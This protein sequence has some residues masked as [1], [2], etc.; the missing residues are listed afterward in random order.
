[1]KR[2]AATLSFDKHPKK[3]MTKDLSRTARGLNQ[4]FKIDL[5]PIRTTTVNDEYETNEQR[6]TSRKNP[7]PLIEDEME[8]QI[9]PSKVEQEYL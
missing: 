5:S 9:R 4:A 7:L 1:L 2:E 3:L 8:F 6:P